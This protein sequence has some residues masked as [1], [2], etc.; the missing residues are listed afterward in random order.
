MN[1]LVRFCIV[2]IVS[3]VLM[4]API[5][6]ASADS[7]TSTGPGRPAAHV[8]CAVNVEALGV[9]WDGVQAWAAREKETGDA[10]AEAMKQMLGSSDPSDLEVLQMQKDG[11]KDYLDGVAKFRAGQMTADLGEITLLGSRLR[12]TLPAS[13]RSFVKGRIAKVRSLYRE[14]WYDAFAG[15]YTSGYESLMGAN[16]DGWYS[17]TDGLPQRAVNAEAEFQQ[18]YRGLSRIC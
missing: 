3:A 5:G 13:H 11:A 14:Y 9:L 10:L 12:G 8:G 15:A 1:A 16:L 2:A 4:A 17:A 6:Q 7:A 18:F